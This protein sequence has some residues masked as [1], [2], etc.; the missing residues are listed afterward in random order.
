MRMCVQLVAGL[1]WR[2]LYDTIS[3]QPGYYV[4][5]RSC[6]LLIIKCIIFSLCPN[7]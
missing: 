1:L 2:M 3:A 7:H 5:Y 4:L 6:V